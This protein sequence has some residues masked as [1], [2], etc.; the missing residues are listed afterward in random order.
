[1]FKSLGQKLLV[2]LA[3]PVCHWGITCMQCSRPRAHL[4]HYG[5]DDAACW[6][7]LGPL[8]WVE[9][10]DNTYQ[11]SLHNTRY[12]YLEDWPHAR[13][14]IYAF[15]RREAYDL[16]WADPGRCEYCH[17]LLNYQHVCI[18]CGVDH[19]WPVEPF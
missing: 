12:A 1:M 14:F 3:A 9:Y 7:R 15:P 8:T 18:D 17:A 19:S 4:P 16:G 6:W 13:G 2:W 11:L 10:N 5:S